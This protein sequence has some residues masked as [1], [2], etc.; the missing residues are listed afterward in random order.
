MNRIADLSGGFN[1]WQDALGWVAGLAFTFLLFFGLS[2]LESVVPESPAAQIVDLRAVS[3]PLEPPPPRTEDAAPEQPADTTAAIA[4][5]EIG[6]SDS[7]VHIAVVPPDL[8][9]LVPTTHE[10]VG[11]VVRLGYLN[12][13]LKPRVEVEADLHRV[14]Q[15]SEVD[16]PPHAIVRVAPPGTG[17]FFNDTH[18]MRVELMLV[19]DLNGRVV[20]ARVVESSGKPEFDN[21]VAQTVRN[22]W[23]FSPAIRRGK[24]VKCLAQQRI[25]VTVGTG[26][27]FETQ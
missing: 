7:P 18:S 13:T 25:R 15:V 24:K 26:T 11:A 21:L 5:L 14:Y 9:A 19:I 10:P 8:E 3:M 22:D 27:P 6:A 20:S 17:R 4:G 12:P 23:E 2:R 1:G 16:R